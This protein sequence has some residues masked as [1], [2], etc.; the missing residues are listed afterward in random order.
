MAPFRDDDNV[1]A[2]AFDGASILRSLLFQESDLV[3]QASKSQP[4][5]QKGPADLTNAVGALAPHPRRFPP[6]GGAMPISIRPNPLVHRTAEERDEVAPLHVWMAPGWQ[7][8]IWRAALRS[9]AVMCPACRCSPNRLLALMGSA[10]RGLI[11]RTGSTSQR[12]ARL[13]SVAS[14]RPT[15]PSRVIAL[16]QAPELGLAA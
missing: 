15:V 5:S 12:S 9:L 16:S 11:I 6:A 3:L 10:N 4:A 8:I 1:D 7:E 14:D 13:L 2:V